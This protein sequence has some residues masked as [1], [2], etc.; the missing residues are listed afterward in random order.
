MIHDLAY[1]ARSYRRFQQNK[2]VPMELIRSLIDAARMAPSSGNLQ[3]VR[4]ALSTN[5]QTNAQLFPHL[6]W[7]KRIA[8]WDG[9]A[10]GERPAAYIVIGCDS[11]Y[12]SFHGTDTGVA[13]QTMH[14]GFAEAGVACCMLGSIDAKAIAQIIGFPDT[15]TVTMVLALG[16][17]GETII[18]DEAQTGS[19]LAYYHA[20]DQTHHVPKLP[21]E[22]VLITV[23]D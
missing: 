10:E 17:P 23:F 16:Y 6:T 2:P 8:D 15:I 19:D 20:P 5:P 12:Q 22:K 18:V 11:K 4:F 1:K 13:A 9:P 3:I 21:L 14:L 7:A